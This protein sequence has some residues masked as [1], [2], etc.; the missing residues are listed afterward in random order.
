MLKLI[1]QKD[2]SPDLLYAEMQ[3][4]FPKNEMK[5]IDIFKK[6]LKNKNY[7]VYFIMENETFCGYFTFLEFADN[8]ILLEYFAINKEFHSRGYGSETFKIIQKTFKYKGCY[9]EVEKKNP[10]KINT[11]RRVLFYENLGA[12][13]LDINYLYPN[14][15]GVLPMDL[16]FMSFGQCNYLPKKPEVLNNIKTAF[17]EIHFDICNRDNILAEIF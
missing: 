15:L 16:Y 11:F 10:D 2:V 1:E 7:K 6:V 4:Q 12:K 13:K 14:I 3:K 17:E 8:T 5:T 9:L